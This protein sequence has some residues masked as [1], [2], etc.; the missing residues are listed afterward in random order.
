MEHRSER[1]FECRLPVELTHE[2]RS[3]TLESRNLSL[4]GIFLPTELEL[5][6]GAHVQVRFRTGMQSEPVVVDGEVRWSGSP[7]EP[8][9]GVRFAGLRARDVWALNKLF[10]K[11]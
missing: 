11:L 8:G 10:E 3:Y 2:G 6:F 5:P 4:G 9:I 7:E 1:R